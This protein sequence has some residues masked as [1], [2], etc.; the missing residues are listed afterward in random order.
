ME[1]IT[2]MGGGQ[3][4]MKVEKSLAHSRFVNKWYLDSSLVWLQIINV[5]QS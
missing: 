1:T 2:L 3:P 5:L 4:G